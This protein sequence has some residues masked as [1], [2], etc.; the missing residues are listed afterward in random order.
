MTPEEAIA[1]C[2]A[3]WT[4]PPIAVVDVEERVALRLADE[5]PEA[6]AVVLPCAPAVRVFVQ[7]REGGPW[8]SAY[9]H[10]LASVDAIVGTLLR[11]PIAVSRGKRRTS[12]A[13]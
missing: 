11:P 8:R 7:M 1:R 9:V 10:D 2:R 6:V 4:H 5:D 13:A 12:K 3:R